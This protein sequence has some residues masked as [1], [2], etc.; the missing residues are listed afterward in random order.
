LW[1]PHVG[2]GGGAGIHTTCP[3]ALATR[4]PSLPR[5]RPRQQAPRTNSPPAPPRRRLGAAVTPPPPSL[6]HC[7]A[8]PTPPHR[9]R[10]AGLVCGVGGATAIVLPIL[11]RR[12]PHVGCGGG[13]GF[14]QGLVESEILSLL[15]DNSWKY[16][17]IAY[18]AHDNSETSIME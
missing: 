15:R 16:K 1:P 9:R 2:C 3:A 13:A 8:I 5:Q 10:A 4:R 7:D 6:C 18:R 17:M 14:H 11:R 12:P